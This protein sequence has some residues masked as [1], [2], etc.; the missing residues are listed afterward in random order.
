MDQESRSVLAPIR[1]RPRGRPTAQRA[2]DIDKT[3]LDVALELFLER[4]FEGATI[5]GVAERARV[6]KGTVY[7]R[8]PGKEALFKRVI[9]HTLQNWSAQ[10]GQFDSLMPEDIAGRL[11]FH[12]DTLKRMFCSQDVQRFTRL[13]DQTASEFPDLASFWIAIGVHDYRDLIARD[14]AEAA[15]PGSGDRDWTFIAEMFLHALSGW[16]RTESLT[17][18]VP[19]SEIRNHIEKLVDAVTGM[20]GR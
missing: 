10:A 14:L 12:A 9:E 3:I 17:G 20:I 11:R 1:P 18:D 4:G 2:E 19:E 6:S 13:M 7:A 15:G 8:F 5:E 16:L